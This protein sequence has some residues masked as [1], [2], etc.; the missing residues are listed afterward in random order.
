M[1][2]PRP[3][4]SRRRLLRWGL[5]GGLLLGAGALLW[6]PGP[7]ARPR[8]AGVASLRALD[9]TEAAIL[10]A[11]AARL[12]DPGAEPQ[13]APPDLA[14]T[15]SFIDGFLADAHPGVREEMRALLGAF[16]RL[17]PLAVARRAR[18]TEL[19]PGAQ[20][21]VL[22]A[23]Q[24]GPRGMRMGFTAM[25]QLAYMAHYGRDATW[26]GIGYD[27]PLVEPGWNGG[28][29]GWFDP[30]WLADPGDA[31]VEARARGRHA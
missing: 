11:V 19:A 13:A 15:V 17:G 14:R 8:P 4:I 10:A 3:R 5:G 28:E 22:D 6:R 12:L 23:W 31:L 27:G 29:V 9:D 30:A 26:P 24:R 20:D 1:S 25:K 16:E 7:G 18:F 21:A 2:A